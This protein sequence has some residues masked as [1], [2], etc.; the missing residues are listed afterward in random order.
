M[1]T[2]DRTAT[3]L[4]AL[5]DQHHKEGPAALHAHIL[6]VFRVVE[7]SVSRSEQPRPE[8]GQTWRNRSSARLV[9]ITAIERDR[10]RWECIDGSLGPRTGSVW[11]SYWT[12]RFDH[13]A[14]S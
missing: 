10:I 5:I 4:A 6:D 1:K 12:D 3:K 2:S 14:Q 9:T 7:Q 11:P 13:E 8:V